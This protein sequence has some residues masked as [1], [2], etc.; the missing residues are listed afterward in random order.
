MPDKLPYS[1]LF[2]YIHPLG[3]MTVNADIPH[4]V[5]DYIQKHY[6]FIIPAGYLT[7]DKIKKALEL[8]AEKYPNADVLNQARK[9]INSFP[10]NDMYNVPEH[11]EKGTSYFWVYTVSAFL[12][13]NFYQTNK[14]AKDLKLVVRAF[15]RARTHKT[16]WLATYGYRKGGNKRA[17][18]YAAAK[19]KA[20]QKWNTFSNAMKQS[21]AYT[22]A[23]QLL[24]Y[25]ELFN[26]LSRL[27]A[28]NTVEGWVREWEREEKSCVC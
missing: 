11:D 6:D 16:L 26:G 15:D 20:K 17:D 10:G 9:F 13:L 5:Q 14:S 3:A 22:A 21:K 25:P 28:T 7:A 24:D 2:P 19:E 1:E 27:P 18:K 8:L 12:F 4:S 23:L